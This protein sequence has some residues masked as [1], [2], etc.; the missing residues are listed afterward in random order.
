MVAFTDTTERTAVAL[1]VDDGKQ[2]QE[3]E[4]SCETLESSISFGYETRLVYTQIQILARRCRQYV[5]S[6]SRASTVSTTLQPPL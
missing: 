2:E 6:S 1:M 3:G 4:V 5:R